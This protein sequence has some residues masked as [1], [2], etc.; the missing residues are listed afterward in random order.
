M[1]IPIEIQMNGI[2]TWSTS[3]RSLCLDYPAMLIL[4]IP[5]T[6]IGIARTQWSGS[7]T[8]RYRTA[9]AANGHGLEPGWPDLLVHAK[10]HKSRVRPHGAEVHRNWTMEK[11]LKSVPNVVDVSSFGG[12]TREYQVR[13][14]PYKLIRI[15]VN[16]SPSRTATGKQER[17]SDGSFIQEGK[18]QI[19]IREL[20]LFGRT[21]DIGRAVL[22]AQHGTPVRVQDVG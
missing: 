4:T 6:T 8:S 10:E 14:D 15:W 16:P 1:T 12:L 7:R 21:Q 13:I 18:Q 17:H 9:S 19:D 11:Q 5:P 3:D 2:L 22:I 20:G